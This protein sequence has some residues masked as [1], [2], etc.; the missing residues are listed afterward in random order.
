[1]RNSAASAGSLTCCSQ[2]RC[3]WLKPWINTISAPRGFPHSWAASTTPSAAATLNDFTL[4]AC[5]SK[6][7]GAA[8]RLV[9]MLGLAHGYARDRADDKLRNA[10]A[11]HNLERHGPVID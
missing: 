4:A 9:E 2:E 7:A 1:M 8:P 10:R 5:R 3:D 6:T 11:A